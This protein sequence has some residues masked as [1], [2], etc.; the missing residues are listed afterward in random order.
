[1]AAVQGSCLRVEIGY[2][3]EL[4]R[5]VD[6]ANS[7][8]NRK[9]LL[10][11]FGGV[12]APQICASCSA[13]RLTHYLATGIL[14][15]ARGLIGRLRVSLAPGSSRT[16]VTGVLLLQFAS[17]VRA[18]A[19]SGDQGT[20]ERAT[21]KMEAA[22][23]PRTT[24]SVALRH[25]QETL[26][27]K[28]R[29]TKNSLELTRFMALRRPWL[30][31]GQLV[32][33]QRPSARLAPPAHPGVPRGVSRILTWRA[34]AC[35]RRLD[36]HFDAVIWRRRTLPNCDRDPSS[37]YQKFTRPAFATPHTGGVIGA[38]CSAGYGG[39]VTPSRRRAYL[40]AII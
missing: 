17:S 24:A 22:I 19:A 28:G 23:Q 26:A 4:Q 12:N 39:N 33:Y 32:G 14:C 30:A 10:P 15:R 18:R 9:C 36:R 11:A 6:L 16:W 34:W 27:R 20:Y 8:D 21:P 38:D 29:K 25:V 3:Q 1:M 40:R 5:A 2:T 13:L 37:P 31:E 7:M 35:P